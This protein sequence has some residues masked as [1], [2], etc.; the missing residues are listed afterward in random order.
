MSANATHPNRTLIRVPPRRV[1]GRL[2]R[3]GRGLV[4]LFL[5]PI[6]YFLARSYGTPGLEF[7]R[8]SIAFAFSLLLGRKQHISLADILRLSVYPMDSFRY[9]EFDFVWDALSPHPSRRY[10]DVSSPRLFPL[11]YARNN[12]DLQVDLINPDS[13]DLA[14]TANWVEA[15]GIGDRCVL[16]GCLIGTAPFE[17]ESFDAV[18]S[19]SVLEHIPEDKEAIQI[20]W[21][22]V[23]PGGRLCLTVPCAAHS[24]EEFIDRN[25]Y[26]VLKPNEEGVFFFQRFYDK[27]LLAEHIFT[28]TGEP[29]SQSIYGERSPGLYHKNQKAKMSD[30][31][32]D[33]WREPYM[34]SREYDYFDTLDK[35]PGIGVIAMEFVKPRKC[36]TD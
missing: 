24:F 5:G 22:S 18:T 26:G 13:A 8:D 16:H 29:L 31:N 36:G 4:G 6:Y 14:V 35:L 27:R 23:K 7:R 9:F 12:R 17:S 19:I 21:D 20:M 33:W 10:L 3:L 34:M 28:V 25:E 1:V 30:P 2:Q 15:L 32:Y 11:M